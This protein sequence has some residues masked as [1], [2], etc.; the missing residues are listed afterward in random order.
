MGKL[1]ALLLIITLTGCANHEAWKEANIAYY[2]ALEQPLATVECLGNKPVMT[3]GRQH[4]PPPV[5]P[6][7]WY[8]RPITALVQSVTIVGSM[9]AGAEIIES[10]TESRGDYNVGGDMISTSNN[11]PGSATTNRTYP[12]EVIQVEAE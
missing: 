12:V 2:K 1:A 6:D 10:L 3:I 4:I 9:L 7:P 11:G 8:A 5:L